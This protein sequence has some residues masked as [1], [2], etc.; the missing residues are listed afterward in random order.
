MSDIQP[1]PLHEPGEP[2]LGAAPRRRAGSV[3]IREL[4]QRDREFRLQAE[5]A[6]RR[7]LYLRV[8]A[9]VL[10]IAVLIGLGI[11]WQQLRSQLDQAATPLK[12]VRIA[13]DIELTEVLR[14]VP[15]P[16]REAQTTRRKLDDAR[17]DLGSNDLVAQVRGIEAVRRFLAPRIP[18]AK[19][20]V[21]QVIAPLYPDFQERLDLAEARVRQN[22]DQYNAAA[23][24]YNGVVRRFPASLVRALL[25]Y[26]RSLP[27][28][29]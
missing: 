25:D 6:E 9:A 20:R 18:R 17:A 16:E 19:A 21:R 12:A 29:K 8:A 11:T 28:L 14:Y 23:R 7:A 2:D 5:R 27:A 13:L 3:T 26:P 4:E 10:F 24:K 1:D 15:I 22:S